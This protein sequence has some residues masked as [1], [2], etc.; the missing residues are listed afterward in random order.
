M[1]EIYVEE[2]YLIILLIT[3]RLFIETQPLR[4]HASM[5]AYTKYMYFNHESLC[6]YYM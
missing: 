4:W 5:L 3:I 6:K 1:R 2:V